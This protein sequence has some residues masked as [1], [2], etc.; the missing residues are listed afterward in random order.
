M[1]GC[2]CTAITTV[3]K[4]APDAVQPDGRTRG[5]TVLQTSVSSAVASAVPSSCRHRITDCSDSLQSDEASLVRQGRTSQASHSMHQLNLYRT[6][7]NSCLGKRR[8]H[9]RSGFGRSDW[10]ESSVTSYRI[11]KSPTAQNSSTQAMPVCSCAHRCFLAVCA[12]DGRID[13]FD[14]CFHTC[15]VQISA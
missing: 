6:E 1:Y 2:P 15:K 9:L 11:L 13:A 14:V 10:A 4:P 12:M 7:S 8:P 5:H 3:L